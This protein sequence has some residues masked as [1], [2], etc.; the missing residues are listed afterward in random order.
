[1]RKAKIFLSYAMADEKKV[2]FLRDKLVEN[3]FEI[4]NDSGIAPGTSWHD[5]I[6]YELNASDFLVICLTKKLFRD[7]KLSFAY[8][9]QFLEDAKK[10]DIAIILVLLEDLIIPDNLKQFKYV[11][12][13]ENKYAEA[14]LLIEKIKFRSSITF[15]NLSPKRFE[16]MIFDLLSKLN[17]LNIHK[18]TTKLDKGIDFIA[19]YIEQDPFGRKRKE[20][21]LIESKLYRQERFSL[22]SLKDMLARHK[23][24]SI[25]DTKL[26]LITN[27]LLTSVVR[28]YIGELHQANGI[29]LRVIDGNDLKDIIADN[30][31]IQIKYFADEQLS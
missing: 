16:D 7:G 30:K 12:L 31:A 4:R 15:D 26:L 21:W 10:R 18:E 1:M 24:V 19:N 25:D 17:F 5:I 13:R 20:T 22:S 27:S 28:E 2:D 14:D 3:N 23:Y 8:D 9:D 29:D 11:D 6:S